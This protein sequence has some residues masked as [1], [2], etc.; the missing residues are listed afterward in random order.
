VAH[1]EGLPA[2]CS[3]HV[4]HGRQPIR[5]HQLEIWKYS[6]C[7]LSP[8]PLRIGAHVLLPVKCRWASTPVQPPEIS[9]GYPLARVVRVESA[10]G[11]GPRGDWGTGAHLGQGTG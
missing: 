7:G 8:L 1:V 9:S 5:T 11:P 6:V 3:V 4:G 2:G 10:L